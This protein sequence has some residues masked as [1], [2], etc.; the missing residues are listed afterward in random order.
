MNEIAAKL[1][2]VGLPAPVLTVGQHLSQRTFQFT[3]VALGV[4]GD[5]VDD[6]QRQHDSL[7]CRLGL[8]NR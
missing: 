3:D 4:A 5:E 7:A 6:I 2:E 1:G 8:D